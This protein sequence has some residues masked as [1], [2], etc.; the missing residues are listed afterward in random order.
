MP[1]SLVLNVIHGFFSLI[2][3][4][5]V[6]IFGAVVAPRI[7]KLS[8]EAVFELMTRLFPTILSFIEV[9]GMITVVFGA[10]EFLHY[11]IGYYKDGGIQ[12]VTYVLFS[13]GWG[14]CVFVG[15]LFGIVGFTVGLLIGRYFETLFKL[16]RSVDPATVDQIHLVENKLRFYSLLGTAL[17]TI[18]VIFMILAVSFLPLP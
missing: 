7:S 9:S 8:S 5:A 14:V 2:Y 12:E 18:T 16:Y 6:I 10:G 13:T 17:L 1:I 11:M 3:Y 15:A 4:G